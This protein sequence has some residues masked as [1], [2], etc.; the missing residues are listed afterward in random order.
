LGRYKSY[1]DALALASKSNSNA[2]AS[3]Q[4]ILS[5][6]TSLMVMQH[7]KCSVFE[8]FDKVFGTSPNVRPVNP[9]EI[10]DYASEE[11]FPDSQEEVFP[12]NA[13]HV[14]AAAV[15]PAHAAVIAP[16]PPL[17]T[18]PVRAAVPANV[19]TA[20]G[21]A[22]ASFH[23]APSKKEKKMDLGEAYLK[24]SFLFIYFAP[25]ALSRRSKSVPNL[26]R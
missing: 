14:H 11:A 1:K 2:G 18:A 17:E 12:S 26:W 7:K 3:A 15:P 20:G 5:N 25:D 21:R 13:A 10:G 9:Q 8:T 16:P 24:V 4:Q 23:L 19:S 22:A 6:S